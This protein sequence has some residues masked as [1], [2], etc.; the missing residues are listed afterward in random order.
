MSYPISVVISTFNRAELLRGAL[1]SLTEQSIREFEVI[2]VDDGCV[3]HTRQVVEGFHDALDIKYFRQRNSGLAS[4]KNH[5]VFAASGRIIYFFDDDDVATPTLLEEHLSTHERYPSDNCAV[6][7]HTS[8]Q[9]GLTVTP[10][11]EFITEIGCFLFSYPYLKHAQ[12]LDYT[13]FWGGRSSVKRSLLME[14]G[15]FH[16]A[17]TFGCEDIELGYRLSK[18]AGLRVIYNERA[19]SLMARGVALEDFVRRLERQ[20]RSQYIFS[21]MHREP[22]IARWAETTGAQEKWQCI[23]DVY[24]A[25]LQAARNLDALV[26]ERMKRGLEIDELTMKLLYDA[27]WWVFKA[28]KIKGI[29]E[30]RA[31]RGL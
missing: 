7:N 22:E 13:Y 12:E 18:S 6:L 26:V 31:S 15:V 5:G 8:W 19:R 14:H 10:L 16:P 28:T 25:K 2:V 20:G 29:C 24:G 11:M 17:F 9:P 27:Y 21:Q 23:C 3:D 30:E 4:G 1:Q